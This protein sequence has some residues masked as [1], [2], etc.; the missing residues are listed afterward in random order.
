MIIK[1]VVAFKY[2]LRQSWG[3]EIAT[4]AAPV[5][6][7]ATPVEAAM[8]VVRFLRNINNSPRICTQFCL[9]TFILQLY[10]L[11]S[12]C[13]ACMAFVDCAKYNKNSSTDSRSACAHIRQC[14]VACYIRNQNITLYLYRDVPSSCISGYLWVF[15]TLFNTLS[16]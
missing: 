8:Y 13:N 5:G 9:L 11:S 4:A 7:A 14:K 3:C 16:H 12:H 2:F 10:W 6:A 15:F 1:I